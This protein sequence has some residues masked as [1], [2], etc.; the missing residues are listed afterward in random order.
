MMRYL[1]GIDLGTTNSAVAFVDTERHPFSVQ[2]FPIPQ[3][4]SLGRVES[5]QTLPSFCYLISKQEW[6]P[7]SLKLPW[8]EESITFVGEFAKQ[9][10]V[11]TPTRLV[12]S[13]KS[14]LCNVAANRKDRILPLEVADSAQRLSPVEATAKYLIHLKEAWNANIA[15]GDVSAEFE[16]PAIVLTVP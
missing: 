6:P 1:I 3:F 8:K 10:G 15:K 4:I 16:E 5:I 2:L 11:R 13:A 9:Q 12:Q 14:W 7:G